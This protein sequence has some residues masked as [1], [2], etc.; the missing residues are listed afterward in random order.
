MATTPEPTS[1]P[2]RR[3]LRFGLRSLLIIVTLLAVWLGWIAERAERQRRAVAAIH[4]AGGTVVYAHEVDEHRARR[5]NP[6]PP[7]GPTWLHAWIGPHYFQRVEII[8]LMPL[9]DQKRE[10]LPL[11]DCVGARSLTVHQRH[12]TARQLEAIGD[13]GSLDELILYVDTFDD[14]GLVHLARLNRLESL[15][16]HGGAFSAEGIA[17]LCQIPNLKDLVMF[18][19]RVEPGGF[20]ALSK[21]STVEQLDLMFVACRDEDLAAIGAMP[22]LKHL[23]LFS[24]ELSSEDLERFRRRHPAIDVIGY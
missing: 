10:P 13:V 21:L 1:R 20:Q 24:D 2:P 11:R 9:S 23:R 17:C 14:E 15:T 8:Y 3:W 12:L 5:S 16:I 4:A 22:A 18:R 19:T 6:P 7:P